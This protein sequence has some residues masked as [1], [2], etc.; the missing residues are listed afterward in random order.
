MKTGSRTNIKK[1]AWNKKHARTKKY[2][3][4]VN[5]GGQDS[6]TSKFDLL[7]KG[8]LRLKKKMFRITKLD[9]KP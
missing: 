3:T 6:K 7:L 5:R 9:F 1:R 4:Q 2:L 8:K